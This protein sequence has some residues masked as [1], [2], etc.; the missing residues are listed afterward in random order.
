LQRL[1]CVRLDVDRR[2]AE[3]VRYGVNSIPRLLVL[4]SGSEQ[5]VIDI[6]GFVE[7]QPLAKELRRALGLK[8]ADLAPAE[9]TDLARVRQALQNQR[10]ATLKASNPKIARAGLG[11]LVV[12][13]GVFQEAQLAPTAALIRGAGDD[14]IPALIQGMGHRHLAVR[15]GS[16]R[17]L[18]GV[19]RER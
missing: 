1:V 11:Q 13:L 17:T 18:Q 6:Q 4:P 5:P 3:A 15:A 8:P 19:L 12:R 16:Y 10:F 2:P 14:A 9:N 7:A